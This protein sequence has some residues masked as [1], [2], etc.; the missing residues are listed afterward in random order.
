MRGK[1]GGGDRHHW[2]KSL[3]S[4]TI[5]NHGTGIETVELRD[6]G[7]TANIIGPE[8]SGPM[9]HLNC[10]GGT[11]LI[12]FQKTPEGSTPVDNSPTED[13]DVQ[14]G[15]FINPSVDGTVTLTAAA[16]DGIA[17]ILHL[18]VGSPGAQLMRNMHAPR[19]I[20]GDM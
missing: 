2:M 6:G 14:R 9:C 13:I 4:A 18:P 8:V 11:V 19:E 3:T 15:R 17:A 16:D 5:G 1:G 10:A 12:P 7:T 20:I